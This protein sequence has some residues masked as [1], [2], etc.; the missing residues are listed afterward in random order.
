MKEL[1]MIVWLYNNAP[2]RVIVKVSSN[3]TKTLLFYE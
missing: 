3:F 1:S 2:C